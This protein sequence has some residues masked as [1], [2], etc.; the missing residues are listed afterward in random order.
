MVRRKP[1]GVIL[2]E[3]K[4]FKV[5]WEKKLGKELLTLSWVTKTPKKNKGK[6]NKEMV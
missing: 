4:A 2:V 1:F 3:I 5:K 6:W